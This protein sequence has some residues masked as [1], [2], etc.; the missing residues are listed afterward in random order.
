M[1]GRIERLQDAIKRLHGCESRHLRSTPVLE[2]FQGRIVWDGEV[3]VFSLTDHPNARTCYAWI[4][5]QDDGAERYFAV[6]GKPPVTSA[7]S[8]VRAMII[9]EFKKP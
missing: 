6:L 4:Q 9:S 5:K 3:E 2:T 8:A 7:K 1:M